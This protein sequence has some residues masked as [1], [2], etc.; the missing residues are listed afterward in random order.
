MVNVVGILFMGHKSFVPVVPARAVIV[1]L[2]PL[3][4][5][6][7]GTNEAVPAVTST[8]NR[9]MRSDTVVPSKSA[10]MLMLWGGL[11]AMSKRRW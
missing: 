10:K 9:P 8:G 11:S 5:P 7:F 1:L 6:V 2:A 4:D 3:E